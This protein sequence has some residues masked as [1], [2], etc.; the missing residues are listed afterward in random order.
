MNEKHH[1]LSPKVNPGVVGLFLYLLMASG[2]NQRETFV[3][4]H[5]LLLLLLVVVSRAR[6]ADLTAGAWVVAASVVVVFESRWW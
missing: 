3:S 1:V 6:L 4:T 5:L 2:V